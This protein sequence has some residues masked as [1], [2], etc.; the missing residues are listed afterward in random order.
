MVVLVE[1]PAVRV[2]TGFASGEPLFVIKGLL[3]RILGVLRP[4]R[5]SITTV[6]QT[7]ALEIEGS[8]E[9][10]QVDPEK[11]PQSFQKPLVKE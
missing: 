10:S 3:W 9:G 1:A 11:T 5:G 8:S 7:S 6:G 4:L 2:A